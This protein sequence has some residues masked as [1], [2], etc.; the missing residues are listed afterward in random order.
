VASRFGASSFGTVFPS[1]V[2]AD[3][4]LTRVDASCTVAKNKMIPVSTYKTETG[5]GKTQS[6]GISNATPSIGA[7]LPEHHDWTSAVKRSG[8]ATSAVSARIRVGL[9]GYGTAGRVF[10][11]PFIAAD[12]AYDL[13]AVVT[14]RADLVAAEHAGARV[15]GSV[16]DLLAA[17]DLDLIVV[18]SPTFLHGAH[19][20]A[21]LDS[22]RP[23]VVD[24]PFAT[25]TAEG[26]G[27]I[28]RAEAAGLLF[29]VFQNRRW[30]GDFRTIRRLLAEGAL[31]E[32]CRFES[33][34][35]WWKPVVVE[36]WKSQTAAASGGGI[37]FDLGTHLID[38]A[39]QLF[40]PARVEYAELDR[41]RQG[42]AADDDAFVALRHETGVLSHLWMSSVAARPGPRF[43]VLGT[44][45][46]YESWGLDPQEALLKA[47]TKPDAPGFGVVP[48]A[49][50][51]TL[52]PGAGRPVRPDD[53][54]YG[55][56]Y[57]GLATA[58]RAGGA[59][60]VDARDSL[61]AL[62]IIESIHNRK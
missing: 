22:G 33:R 28:E 61:A 49:S 17:D 34:F 23:V 47:G 31:G 24:K 39:L 51:G 62:Q 53:G 12:P 16:D 18:A 21:A 19:A 56:F 50:W 46:G 20:A 36:S 57:R 40:G 15:V 32:V 10:H 8:A 27:L 29:T 9:I 14:S 4:S 30:D 52:G 35:E 26:R 55:A 42:T 5:G 44:S 41:R 25:T 37:L 6:T 3:L 1:P 60:P 13:T 45:S 58:L 11:A 43:R 59:P 48:E 38:Q 54:D 2:A 7:T